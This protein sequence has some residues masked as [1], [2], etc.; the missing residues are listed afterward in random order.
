[1]ISAIAVIAHEKKY[2]EYNAAMVWNQ[3][4]IVYTHTILNT[5]EPSIT[6]TVGVTVLPIPL[7]AAIVPSIKALTA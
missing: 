5:Q 4:K 3:A 1:M 6:I 7:E 2:S